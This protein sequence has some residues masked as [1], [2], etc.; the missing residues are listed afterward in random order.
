MELLKQVPDHARKTIQNL[1]SECREIVV[2]K[3]EVI[4]NL[5]VALL[6]E[7]HVLMGGVPGVAKTTIAKTFARAVGLDFKRIQCSPDILPADIVGTHIFNLKTNSFRLE[8]GPIFS[9]IV[10]IDEI[11]RNTPKTNSAVLEALQE[12]QVTIEGETQALPY[13]FLVIA[14]QSPVEFHGVFPLPEVLIDR[15]LLSLKIGYPSLEEEL[16]ITDKLYSIEVGEIRQV[17]TKEQISSLAELT[18]RVFLAPQVRSYIVNLV[19]RTR[20]MAGISLG[21][22]PRASIALTKASRAQALIKG[23][24]YVLPDD[25]KYLAPKI[26]SHRIVLSA[27]ERPELSTENVVASLLEDTPIPQKHS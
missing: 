3:T 24:L 15:F 2:G 8:K 5:L 22:S 18:R 13:P 21:A 27:A 25:V 10:L 26:L 12:R 19:N 9:N 20:D 1:L 23:R 14:T 4:E 17:T 7:G 11:N 16:E 6:S